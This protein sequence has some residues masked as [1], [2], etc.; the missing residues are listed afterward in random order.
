[1]ESSPRNGVL[2][3]SNHG[4][5]TSR[6]TPTME[7]V[8]AANWGLR[9]EDPIIDDHGVVLYPYE[10]EFE[11]L[12]EQQWWEMIEYDEMVAVDDGYIQ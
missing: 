6:L 12:R 1:M 8:I 5:V 9:I 2:S 4:D 7:A 11:I 10:Q 3:W